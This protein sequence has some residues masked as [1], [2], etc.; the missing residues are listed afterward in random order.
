MGA[1]E[2]RPTTAIQQKE[3]RKMCQNSRRSM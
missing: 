1:E 2:G 3:E